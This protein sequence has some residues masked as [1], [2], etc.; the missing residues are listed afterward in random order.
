MNQIHPQGWGGKRERGLPTSLGS[1]GDEGG[2]LGVIDDGAVV[3]PRGRHRNGGGLVL[4][5][6]PHHLIQFPL[7]EGVAVCSGGIQVAEISQPLPLHLQLSETLTSETCI[8]WW[9]FW[10]FLGVVC[11]GEGGEGVRVIHRSRDLICLLN[12][13]TSDASGWL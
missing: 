12:T 2:H 13:E 7:L 10:V 8:D 3:L 5:V 9:P 4:G 11:G 6:L 1:G